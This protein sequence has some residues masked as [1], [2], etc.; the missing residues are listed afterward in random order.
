MSFVNIRGECVKDGIIIGVPYKLSERAYKSK[1][2]VDG[3]KHFIS[4]HLNAPYA[5]IKWIVTRE[6]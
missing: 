3:I 1:N 4:S 5:D 2:Y 6:Q